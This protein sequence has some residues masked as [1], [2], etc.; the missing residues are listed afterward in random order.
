[1]TEESIV[2][3]FEQAEDLGT[4]EWIY[5]EGGEPFLYYKLLC[6]GVHLAKSR[7]FKV[8]IV[9][10]AHWA[11]GDAEALEL[12]RPLS[13]TNLRSEIYRTI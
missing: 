6:W 13:G 8:G 9:T 3:I 11:T 5:F 4:I 12:L 2:H 1:M 10:N 7:G